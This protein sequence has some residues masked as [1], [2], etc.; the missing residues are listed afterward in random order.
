MGW[1]IRYA[2]NVIERYA[3]IA[4]EDSDGV[5]VLLARAAEPGTKV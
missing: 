3:A 4:P 1:S 2:Q 5:P